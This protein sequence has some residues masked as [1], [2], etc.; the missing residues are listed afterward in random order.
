MCQ[1]APDG[2][3]LFNM[4]QIGS[5]WFICS[6]SKSVGFNEDLSEFR[7]FLPQSRISGRNF[8]EMSEFQH[9]WWSFQSIQQITDVKHERQEDDKHQQSHL[10][11]SPAYTGGGRCAPG[12]LLGVEAVVLLRRQLTLLCN[13]HIPEDTVKIRW[14]WASHCCC[15]HS[16]TAGAGAR[17]KG[18]LW[19]HNLCLHDPYNDAKEWMVF[20][21]TELREMFKNKNNW[22][23]DFYQLGPYPLPPSLLTGLNY[24]DGLTRQQGC[25]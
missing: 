16:Y 2:S 19:A 23:M 1:F 17:C 3:R 13:V 21:L 5:G 10:V 25:W 18:C 11:I 12:P 24:W 20:P 9:H 6:L 7:L 22:K 8:G 4:F 15:W 14:K